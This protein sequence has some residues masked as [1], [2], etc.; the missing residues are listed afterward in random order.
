MAKAIKV[1][2]FD[3][4]NVLI[5]FDYNIAA[6]RI[7]HFCG[8]S[9]GDIPGLLLGSS[10][11]G[12]FEMGKIIPEEFF[13]RI[14]EMLDLS[15]SYERFV[16]I[17]NEVFFMSAKNRSVYSLANKLRSNYKIAV[18]SN[19]NTL[20]YEYLKERFP[21]FGIFHEVFA[22]CKMGLVKPDPKIYSKTLEALGAAAEE[23][24]YTDD[25]EELVKSAASLKINSFVFKDIKKLK[26]DLAELGV[27]LS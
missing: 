8:R 9:P 10:L 12:I 22:S 5:D 2:L 19:I 14:K 24:F 21:V 3:L 6:R 27:A 7:A 15:I 18:L 17:W 23:V 25:R 11:T 13:S 20:H 1:I 4:G 26:R 16:P